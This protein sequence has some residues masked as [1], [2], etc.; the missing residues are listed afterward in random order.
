[1]ITNSKIIKGLSAIFMPFTKLFYPILPSLEAD[2]KNAK[3]DVKARE[4]LAASLTFSS[5]VFLTL[6]TISIAIVMYFKIFDIVIAITIPFFIGILA[7]LQQLFN[8][9]LLASKRI[10]NIETNLL[11]AMEDMLVQLNSGVPLF[12]IMVNVSNSDYGELSNEFKKIVKEIN[13]GKPQMEALSDV[14]QANPSVFFRRALW[15]ISNGMSGGAYMADILRETVKSI[16]SEQIIQIQTY[17]SR[18]SPLAMFY[19]LIAVIIPALAVTF[20]TVLI[21]FISISEF[22]SKSIFFGLYGF[23][24][25]FQIMFLGMIKSRRPS[26]L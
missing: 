1:M 8:P 20:I 14:A 4:Y 9:K 25:L 12:N 18:L 13:A 15:Q 7:F 10:K 6:S 5:I 2:I 19:T 23:V 17:G 16:S 11:P 26:L 24:I 3:I 22:V 21:S